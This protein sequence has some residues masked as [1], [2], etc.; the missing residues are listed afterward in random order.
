MTTL[1]LTGFVL[2]GT[3]LTQGRFA[4]DLTANL[5]L[6]EPV[7]AQQTP[8]QVIQYARAA[9]EIEQVRRRNYAQAKRILGGNVPEDVC[10][11]QTIP[12]EV[13]GI[14]EDFS[15]RAAEI[16]KRNGLTYGQFNDITRRK[17]RDPELRQKI[18]QELLRLQKS[19]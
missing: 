15:R 6:G 19:N 10:R 14:C 16:I 17:D 7:S 8:E 11:Q 2:G 13:K 18:Q 4:P 1:T 5:F 12:S 3:T 9:Y